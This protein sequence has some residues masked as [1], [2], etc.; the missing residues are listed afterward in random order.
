[1]YTAVVYKY[2]TTVHEYRESSQQGQAVTA[3]ASPSVAV[4]FN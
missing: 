1:M 3:V 4:A 2:R